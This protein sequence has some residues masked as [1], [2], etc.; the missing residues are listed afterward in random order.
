MCD[1]NLMA[2]RDYEQKEYLYE[3]SLQDLPKCDC[4]GEPITY[5]YLFLT[6][7]LVCYDDDC[8]K[9]VMEEYT[10]DKKNRKKV[11]EWIVEQVLSGNRYDWLEEDIKDV[12]E[13]PFVTKDMIMGVLEYGNLYYDNV[14]LFDYFYEHS[15]EIDSDF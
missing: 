11:E 7:E 6:D 10:A 4:C 14:F 3:M 9:A 13:V 2:L 5:G 1:G 12:H 8:I 15:E